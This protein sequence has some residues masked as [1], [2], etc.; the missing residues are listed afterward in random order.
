MTRLEREQLFHAIAERRT[1]PGIVREW[2]EVELE[3]RIGSIDARTEISAF[4]PVAVW[5]KIEQWDLTWA[6]AYAC[7]LK[8]Q[9]ERE[10]R[11]WKAEIDQRQE[12]WDQQAE[13]IK[14]ELAREKIEITRKQAAK[15]RQ[16]REVLDQLLGDFADK[17][18]FREFRQ[19]RKLERGRKQHRKPKDIYL[20]VVRMR[21]LELAMPRET[22]W[23]MEMREHTRMAYLPFKVCDRE[24]SQMVG[25]AVQDRSPEDEAEELEDDDEYDEFED[26]DEAQEEAAK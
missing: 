6:A 1:Q 4:L 25:L 3:R 5:R 24:F 15:A 17:I 10:T 19:V 26:D 22:L 11:E 14:R 23:S 18:S 9:A 21:S 16:E 12:T 2:V 20:S 7:D 8:F 13:R